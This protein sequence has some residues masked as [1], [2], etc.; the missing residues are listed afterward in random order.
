MY[1]LANKPNRKTTYFLLQCIC[2][3]ELISYQTGIFFSFDNSMRFSFSVVENGLDDG[4][5]G[6][7]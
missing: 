5:G 1:A 7:T 4:I 3:S 2:S 6:P